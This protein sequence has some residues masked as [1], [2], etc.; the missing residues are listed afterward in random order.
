M[1]ELP[2]IETIKNT[3]AP[4]S[5][6]AIKNIEFRR[7]DII[8]RQDFDPALTGGKTI[9]EFARRG[10]YLVIFLDRSHNIIV[11]LGMSGRF[12]QVEEDAQVTA[13]HIHAVFYLTNGK[14]LLYED[15]RRFGGIYFVRDHKQFFAKM[16]VEPLS[17]D[18]TPDYIDKIIKNRKIAIKSLL[19]CQNLISGIGNIYAD[20]AL[21]AAG[22]RPD[23]PS[24]SLSPQETTRLCRAIKE[25]LQQSIELHGT[26]FRDFRDGYNQAGSFQHRLKVYGKN[27]EKCSVCGQIICKEVIGGRGSHFCEK[28]QS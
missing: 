26:T 18:F 15:P 12:Y 24:A 1:P 21:F 16:G 7:S 10:K 23:R 13:R 2:E 27:R 3:L 22:I 8:R 14:K 4:N 6:A 25:V 28:C 17:P 20:E 11:H 9:R 5:G 19:L